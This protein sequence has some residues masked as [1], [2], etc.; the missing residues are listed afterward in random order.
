MK[1][2][3]DPDEEPAWNFVLPAN[4]IGAV[5]LAHTLPRHRPCRARCSH[6]GQVAKNNAS[7]GFDTINEMVGGVI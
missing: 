7:T 2:A 3:Y 6:L 5:R 1:K 4:R